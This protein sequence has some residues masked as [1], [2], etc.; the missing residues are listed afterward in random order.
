MLINDDWYLKRFLLARNRNVDES[1][2][3]LDET[4]RWRNDMYIS[5]VRDYHFP[6]EF[7]QIGALF[8]YEPDLKG[9]L[10]LYMRIRMHHKTAELDEPGKSGL[11]FP[12]LS[13]L[14]IIHFIQL[15]LGFYKVKRKHYV[16]TGLFGLHFLCF[17]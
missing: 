9:N 3:M 16:P 4:M 11:F 14:F 7:Y 8:I 2:K 17:F 1:F 5:Q 15:V 6:S 10:V 12:T 13:Q